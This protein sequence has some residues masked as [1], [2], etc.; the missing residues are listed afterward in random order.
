LHPPTGGSGWSSAAPPFQRFAT[1]VGP[2]RVAVTAP[3]I[4][5]V[6]PSSVGRVTFF[7]VV[8]VGACGSH[9]SG[10]VVFNGE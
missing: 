9:P 5:V 10:N 4:E 8:F 1:P 2:V 3:A 6:L 7:E